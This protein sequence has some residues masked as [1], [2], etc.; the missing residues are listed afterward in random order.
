MEIKKIKES[1]SIKILTKGPC[2]DGW[3]RLKSLNW[4]KRCPMG[5]RMNQSIRGFRTKIKYNI[6]KLEKQ[7]LYIIRNKWYKLEF[8]QKVLET[9][10]EFH[11]Q[12]FPMKKKRDEDVS[13]LQ[14]SPIW[15]GVWLLWGLPRELLRLRPKLEMRN[16][17]LLWWM[18]TK[19]MW[20]LE[21][22][23]TTNR[24]EACIDRKSVV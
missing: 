7:K 20:P 8:S 1:L 22:W 15:D 4:R 24:K 3:D 5:Q 10:S 23:Q 2:R 6:R 17:P 11:N 14:W 9:P 18:V 21:S 19:R 12:N 16:F 13:Y